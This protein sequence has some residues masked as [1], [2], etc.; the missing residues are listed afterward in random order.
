[1]FSPSNMDFL[2]LKARVLE[3][4]P[5]RVYGSMRRYV[6]VDHPSDKLWGLEKPANFVES[7][8]LYTL[9]IDMHRCG[10][11]KLIDKLGNRLGYKLNSKSVLHNS[12]IVRQQLS[13]WAKQHIVLGDQHTWDHAA[14]DVFRPDSLQV[15]STAPNPLTDTLHT[16][17]VYYRG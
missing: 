9:Y 5:D 7:V 17:L 16:S 13:G 4:I 8:L 15:G 1:M 3:R 10:A 2:A 11:H 12:A 6:V 14:R